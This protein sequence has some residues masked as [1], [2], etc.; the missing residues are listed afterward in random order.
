MRFIK[1][2]TLFTTMLLLGCVVS[3]E[4]KILKKQKKKNKEWRKQKFK[5]SYPHRIQKH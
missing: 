2:I 3:K 4:D 5:K 1:I